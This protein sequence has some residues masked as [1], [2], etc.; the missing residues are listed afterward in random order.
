MLE[1]GLKIKHK[2]I[3]L[4][5]FFLVSISIY[6]DYPEIKL[7]NTDDILFRQIQDDIEKFNR[8]EALNDLEGIPALL[9]FKY[10]KKP[11]EDLFFLSARFNLPYETL[12]TLNRV[13]N[14]NDFNA[15]NTIIIPNLPGLFVA[16]EPENELEKIMI[17]WRN[18]EGLVPVAVLNGNN[19]ASLYFYPG[20]RFHSVERAYFLQILFRF[21]LP[22]GEITSRYGFRENPFSGHQEFHQGIDIAAPVGTDVLAAREGTV[23]TVDW[24]DG[25]GNYIIITHSGGYQTVYGHLSEVDVSL[26]QD[27]YSAMIIGKVGNTGYS[28]GPHLHFEIRKEGDS[29]DPMELFIGN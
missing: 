21:P 14:K 17:S 6:S 24:D 4:F 16:E 12:S 28:T 1:K 5:I 15:L 26:N 19:R 7:L 9:F 29:R 13:D 23:T 22:D 25:L 8:A 20:E 2:L 27:V 10:D 11:D 18:T 3:F